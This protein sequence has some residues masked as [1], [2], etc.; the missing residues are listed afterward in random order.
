MKYK[1]DQSVQIDVVNIDKLLN[2]NA[3]PFT[4][5]F[6]SQKFPGNLGQ[7]GDFLNFHYYFA[8]FSDVAR[9]TGKKIIL[10]TAG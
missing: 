10:V 1:S 2:L 3:F 4:F 8:V 5:R 7:I 6:T 9:A